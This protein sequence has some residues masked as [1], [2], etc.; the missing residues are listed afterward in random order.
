MAVLAD[1]ERKALWARFMEELSARRQEISLS[2]SELRAA[3]D[4][5]DTWV[6]N[7]QASFNSAL[8]AAAQ[9]GLTTKQ[10]AAL[11]MYVVNKR[12]EVI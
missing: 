7:N 1:A 3:V 4:A 6:E 2:K 12:Y 10:K 8:P 11:L 9:T 5:V